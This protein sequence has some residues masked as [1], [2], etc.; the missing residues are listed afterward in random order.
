M[1][2]PSK[3]VNDSMYSTMHAELPPQQSK[4]SLVVCPLCHS[5]IFIMAVR[6]QEYLDSLFYLA[7]ICYPSIYLNSLLLLSVL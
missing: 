1:S 4:A 5:F 2:L 6:H 3:L 7:F